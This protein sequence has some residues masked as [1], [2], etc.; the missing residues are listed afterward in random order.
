MAATSVEIPGIA[1][2]VEASR[3]GTSQPRRR[4]LFPIGFVDHAI[5]DKNQSSFRVNAESAA[6]L[7]G[8]LRAHGELD[9]AALRN[10]VTLQS[11]VDAA[12]TAPKQEEALE[13]QRLKEKE[14]EEQRLKEKELKERKLM[15]EKLKEEAL[16]EGR[17]DAWG[18]PIIQRKPHSTG[19]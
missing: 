10:I 5:C 12:Q 8:C 3:I 13:E 1:G 14:L 2:I 11:A 7:D 9:E 17:L 4:C 16:K 18:Q 6:N 19:N 15:E